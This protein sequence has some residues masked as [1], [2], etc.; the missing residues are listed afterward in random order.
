MELFGFNEYQWLV[1]A[2]CVAGIFFTVGKR[3][4]ISDTLEYLRE[5]GEIDYD[6]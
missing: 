4:G 1:V 3:V 5:K 6:D 2:I